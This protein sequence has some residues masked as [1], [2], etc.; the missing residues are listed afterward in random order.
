MMDSF[1]R[2]RRPMKGKTLLFLVALFTMSSVAYA[3]SVNNIA[4]TGNFYVGF[5]TSSGDFQIQGQGLNLFQATPGGPS[6]IGS[7]NLG[8]GCNFSFSPVPTSSFCSYCLGLSGGSLGSVVVEYLNPSVAFSGSAV[9][10]GQSTI[11]VPMT[12]TGTIVG[13]ELVGCEGIVGCSLG[14]EEFSLRVVAHGTGQFSVSP[15]GLIY[16]GSGTFSGFASTATPEPLPLLLT[17]TGLIG[18]W[19]ARKRVQTRQP[20]SR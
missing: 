8:A 19:L 6:F 16:G 9:W 5:G 20:S 4:I 17:G 3:N 11:N 2:R 18:V 12:I 7:C 10:N 15:A 1:R 13:Y 14:P